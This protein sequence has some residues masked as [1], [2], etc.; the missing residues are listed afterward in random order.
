MGV[1]VVLFKIQKTETM[2]FNFF[3]TIIWWSIVSFSQVG[4]NTTT[5]DP[6]S[7]LEIS[8]TNRG[9]LLPRIA[10]TGTNDT[11]TIASPAESLLIYNTATVAGGNAVSPGYYYW[12]GTV[13]VPFSSTT[14][15]NNWSLV[16]NTGTLAGTNFLGTT[17]NQDLVFKSNNTEF[18][19]L[20]TFGVLFTPNAFRNTSVGDFALGEFQTGTNT[21]NTAFGY[22]AGY[23]ITTGNRNVLVG[24]FS[25]RNMTSARRNVGVGY[26]SLFSLTTG[27]QNV[28]IG[29]EALRQITTGVHNV[30]IGD[31][32][33]QSLTTFH[34]RN[35][36]IG[37]LTLSDMTEGQYNS[38]IGFQTG[39]YMDNSDYN[40]A[41][42]AFAMGSTRPGGVNMTDA[43]ESNIGIGISSLSEINSGDHNIAL[44]QKSLHIVSSGSN[45]LAIGERAGEFITT[46]S[47]N[48]LIG[49]Q[50]GSS[51]TSQSNLLFID[52]S[53]T[54]APLYGGDFSSNRAYVNIDLSA[55]PANATRTLN[56]GGDVYAASGFYTTT[57]S[58]PDYVFEHYFKGTS[59][60]DANY[61]FIP[62][63][64]AI[65]FVR[66]FGHLPNVKSLEEIKANNMQI[67]LASTSIKN[68][69]KIEENFI[70]ISELKSENETLKKRVEKLESTI[71][72]LMLKLSEENK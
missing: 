55:I 14:T 56:V 58:Y 57:N 26:Y 54:S 2:K 21:Y 24:G 32:S 62:L 5:P 30:A 37:R 20:K 8:A 29:R 1:R 66:K 3:I 13:W 17:D 53:N 48:I 7:M 11:A 72:T 51:L 67:D 71:N 15:N 12:N 45:N 23:P 47:N 18:L 49:T 50:S 41:I 42:G 70:Y 33:L 34:G 65:A 9:V 69:E 28:A 46:G 22:A 68:L 35:T 39:V 36:A 60:I 31:E 63:N 27:E 25:G 38:V 44:G 40:I 16:G 10:L 4:I 59:K 61:R 52:N 43:S 19:R 6:S 64:D